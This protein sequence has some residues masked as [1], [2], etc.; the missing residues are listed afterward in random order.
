MPASGSPAARWVFARRIWAVTYQGELSGT[1][2]SAAV[3]SCILALALEDLGG[4]EL[5]LDEV[6][7]DCGS[8]PGMDQRDPLGIRR[9]Q[10]VGEGE[11]RFGR[12]VPRARDHVEGHLLAGGQPVAQVDERGIGHAARE[13]VV[14][15]RDGL[16]FAA[17]LRQNLGVRD[18]RRPV[19]VQ[20][21]VLAAGEDRLGGHEVAGERQ[22]QRLVVLAVGRQ[23][24]V[25]GH[26]VELRL[27]G[28]EVVAPD[29]DPAGHEAAEQGV[30]ASPAVRQHRRGAGRSRLPRGRRASRT[31][32]RDLVAGIGAPSSRSASGSRVATSPIAIAGRRAALAG[33]RGWPDRAASA[34]S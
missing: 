28:G 26:R 34:R 22:R 25:P 32:D 31:S 12:A 27:R 23:R 11:E 2:A 20:R 24:V 16:G 3:A 21:A 33:C 6:G 18:D 17:E 14:E 5:R 15:H 13:R 4:H 1:P 7:T 30:D 10:R 29:L 8:Q 9:A 19:E